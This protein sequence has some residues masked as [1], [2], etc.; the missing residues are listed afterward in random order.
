MKK[1]FKIW[2]TLVFIVTFVIHCGRWE[3]GNN[4]GTIPK[5]TS[6][7][8]LPNAKSAALNS[9]LIVT[10][11][12]DMD[13][14]SINT[15]SF[16][17]KQGTTAIAGT[18]SYYGKS[19]IFTPNSLLPSSSTLT[20][21]ITSDAHG[22]ENGNKGRS[23][24]SDYIWTFKTGTSSDIISPVVSAIMPAN[25]ATNVPINIQPALVF[26][27]NIDT[28]TVNKLT[29]L[30]Q[31]GS[32]N[33]T[34]QVSGLSMMGIFTPSTTLS[35]NTTYTVTIS[36]GIQD[37]AGNSLG[38]NFVWSFTTGSSSDVT[39]PTVT[40]K[41]PADGSSDNP[42]N[43]LSTSGFNEWMDPKTVNVKTI[44]LSGPN[45]NVTGNV[46]FVGN[47]L[48]FIPLTFLSLTST[49]ILKILGGPN[50]AKDLSGNPLQTDIQWTFKT[51]G[52]FNGI[53]PT[54]LSSSPAN[55][56]TG[57]CLQ[58]PIS[59]TFNES[60][61]PGSITPLSMK[62]TDPSSNVFVGTMT[63]NTQVTIASFQPL[64]SYASNTQYTMFVSGGSSLGVLDLYNNFMST[65]YELVFTTGTQ[66]CSTSLKLEQVKK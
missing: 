28:R 19:A 7:F 5:V 30:L 35:S 16:T 60:M 8:P 47:F 43:I 29:F 48:T 58:Q 36:S 11:T 12:Q 38:S 22:S 33:V 51:G 2:V 41:I 10:F 39:A 26:S 31:A 63:Y 24:E 37:L 55:G 14:S 34:G 25:G 20:A 27:E 42:I 15:S 59:V 66:N 65:N 44:I 21:T 17:L 1:I 64:N 46:N 3:L 61:N 45:G 50:G 13:T 56:S 4:R 49:Y 52:L 62:L 40:T 23:L 53:Q 6:T 54:I 32:T 57:V 9:K 18:V